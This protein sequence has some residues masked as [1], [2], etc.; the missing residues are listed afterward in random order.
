MIRLTAKQH[1]EYRENFLGVS[2]RCDVAEP[3]T[4]NDS[5][6]KIQRSDVARP[7]IRSAGRVIS[8]IRH[9]GLSRELVQP[10]NGCVQTRALEVGNG[11]EDAGEPV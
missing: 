8:K 10:A 9:S 4:R 6:G 3:D 2:D 7:D 5:E 1:G 11:V